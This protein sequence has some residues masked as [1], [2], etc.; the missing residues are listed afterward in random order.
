MRANKNRAMSVA[1][2]SGARGELLKRRGPAPALGKKK[3]NGPRGPVA[4]PEPQ[5]KMINK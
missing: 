4:S 1:H 2:P 5:E 3:S